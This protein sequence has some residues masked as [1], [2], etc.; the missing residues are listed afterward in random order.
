MTSWQTKKL[1]EIM[2]FKNGLN[3]GSEYFGH[4]TKIVNYT[5]VYRNPSL[6]GVDVNG[7][8]EVTASEKINNGVKAGDVFFTRTSETLEEIGLSS[9]L[10]DDIKDGVF[11]GYVL[12]GRPTA[13]DLVPEYCGY[14]FRNFN[15]RKEIKRK[16]SMTTRALTSGKFL[17]EVNISFP[18][19]PE[20]ARIV[21]VLEVWDEYI[22]KLEQ[23]IALKEQLK[24]GLMQ[25]LLTGKRRL[26]GFEGD[27]QKLKLSDIAKIRKGTQLNRS[28]LSENMAGLNKY[29]VINGGIA[30]SGYT[31]TMNTKAGAITISEGGNSCGYVNYIKEDFWLGGHCYEI[32]NNQKVD[33][34]YLYPFLKANQSKIMS[35]RVG[36]G[37]PNIQKSS[38]ENLKVLLPE[39]K[40]E[41]E[42]LG[43]IML[44]SVI[45]IE[46]LSEKLQIMKLQK[47]Y[48]LKNLITGTIRTP[49][50]LQPLDTSRLERSA[51]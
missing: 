37:L 21:G 45:E 50:D 22:E 28:T 38:L 3:K 46:Q 39:T 4:G 1:G 9:V 29:A 26:P 41:Q 44:H 49:E 31:D 19:K 13:D 36:S 7:L 35:L 42:E 34:I 16:S 48:L 18:E 24:K 40:K 5:D 32:I 6:R 43:L 10:L 12:R 47:K 30:P 20:Q 51:L 11:S 2:D 23:K 27:W 17:S 25:Q 15:F 33:Q 14:L 8:V